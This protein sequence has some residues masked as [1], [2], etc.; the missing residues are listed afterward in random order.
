MK[1]KIS[2]QIATL[3]KWA[4]KDKYYIFF[5][6]FLSVFSGL[7][8]MIPYYGI[9]RIIDHAY[10]GTFNMDVLLQNGIII[11]VSIILRFSLFGIAGVSS[12]KG[13][14]NALFK[15]RCKAINHM[16]KMPLGALNERNTGEI[17]TLLN[18]DIEKLELALAHQLPE[19]VYYLIGPVA[20]FIYLCTV[21]FILALVTLIPFVMAI[22]VMAGMFRGMDKVME[23]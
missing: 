21:N 17:K 12:H 6:I 20:V 7:C 3:I 2:S 1:Q 8:T 23:K 10:T 4:G 9:Y 15:V 11:A 14:Y 5:S 16:A 13:A 18:E 19:F 22:M